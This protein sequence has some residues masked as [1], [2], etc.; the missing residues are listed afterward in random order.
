MTTYVALLRGINV[1]GHGKLPM[2]SLKQLVARLGGQDVATHIQSGNVVFRHPAD[3]AADLAKQLE[4]SIEESE[5]FRPRVLVLTLDRLEEAAAANPYPQGAGD[6]KTLHLYFLADRPQAPALATL[7]RLQNP[8]EEFT[9]LA[10]V[11]YLYAPYGVGR[12]RLAGRVEAAL[13]VSA[14]ARNWR[15]VQKLLE[16]GRKLTA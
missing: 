15:T 3:S 9:L 12:S 16:M 14:T 4:D 6:P 2:V 7:K 5:G 10:D 13:G 1:G 11:F 8:T